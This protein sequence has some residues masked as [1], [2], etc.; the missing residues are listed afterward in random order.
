M[1]EKS[2]A[3]SVLTN[4]GM[5]F[6]IAAIA[7]IA[8]GAGGYEYMEVNPKAVQLVAGCALFGAT[9]IAVGVILTVSGLKAGM[10]KVAESV[11]N[12]E[13]RLD[14]L[15]REEAYISDVQ[16]LVRSNDDANRTREFEA[17]IRDVMQ[18]VEDR[19]RLLE[20]RI[21]ET[22]REVSTFQKTIEATPIRRNGSV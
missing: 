8:L 20:S 19:A 1:K 6:M 10:L 9:L 12:I 11:D 17:R 22:G 16:N 13:R 4:V 21:D 2:T 7:V 3:G 15:N 14:N 18:L 5:G